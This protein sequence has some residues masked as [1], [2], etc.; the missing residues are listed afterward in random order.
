MREFSGSHPSDFELFAHF[1]ITF[2]VW[3]R[4]ASTGFCGAGAIRMTAKLISQEVLSHFF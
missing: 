4:Q 1:S 2:T 3:D